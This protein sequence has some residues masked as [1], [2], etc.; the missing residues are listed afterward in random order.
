MEFAMV[1]ATKWYREFVADFATK[2]AF[3]REAQMVRIRR[4]AAADQA[5][6]ARYRSDV[7]AIANASRF[8]KAKYTFVDA[9]LLER[10]TRVFS[11]RR[12]YGDGFPALLWGKLFNRSCQRDQLGPKLLLHLLRISC[13]QSV[14]ASHRAVGPNGCI[15]TRGQVTDLC[16]ELL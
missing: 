4:C 16:E 6:I 8:G 14:L 2:G 7:L 3:L 15:V 5:A 11:S 13:G 1:P 9:V 10:S 12:F